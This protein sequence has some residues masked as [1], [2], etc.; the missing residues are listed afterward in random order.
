M[1]ITNALQPDRRPFPTDFIAWTAGLTR[2]KR[3]RAEPVGAM[4]SFTFDSLV[5]MPDHQAGMTFKSSFSVLPA[6]VLGPADWRKI[7]T[8]QLLGIRVACRRQM[9]YRS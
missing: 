7:M 4:M 9:R 2:F 5:Q 6:D 1:P 3:L 8:V